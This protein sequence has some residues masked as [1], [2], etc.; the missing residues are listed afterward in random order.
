MASKLM[1][2]PAGGYLGRPGGAQLS[3]IMVRR[4]NWFV[5]QFLARQVELI[6]YTTLDCISAACDQSQKHSIYSTKIL[7]ILKIRSALTVGQYS[8]NA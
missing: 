3:I 6:G 1:P 5:F 8:F 4:S 2:N 7:L